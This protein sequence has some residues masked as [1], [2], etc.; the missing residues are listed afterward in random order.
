MKNYSEVTWSELNANGHISPVCGINAVSTPQVVEYLGVSAKELAAI[1]IKMAKQ[2][3]A[4]GMFTASMK[5]LIDQIPGAE[6]LSGFEYDLPLEDGGAVRVSP[7]PLVY[8]TAGAVALLADEIQN[9]NA[10]D[11]YKPAELK[12]TTSV[13]GTFL[14]AP[15]VFNNPMF[16]QVRVVEIDDEP[17][18][19]GKDVAAALGYSDADQALRKHVDDEDKL[20]RQFNGSGQ[21]R[22]ATVINESGLYSLV[23]SS[24]LPGAKKFRRWITSEVLPSIRKHG[25]YI[26]GQEQMSDEE[27]MAKALIMA[28]SKIAERDRQI[29]DLKAK[30]E[31]DA[32]KVAF[33]EAVHEAKSDI[34][35]EK[36]A[37]LLYDKNGI[38]VGRNNMFL[39]LRNMGYLQ[40]NNLPYQKYLRA[41]YFRTRELLK[42][43]YPFIQTLITG[44]GQTWLFDRVMNAMCVSR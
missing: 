39:L 44:K 34:T 28:Q 36:F 9:H 8:C 23:L 33:A 41:G 5:N 35:V 3:K 22:C 10:K 18:L 43:G 13:S 29:S 38:R 14:C 15:T 12:T 11:A 42:N 40:E 7:G 16:G 19:V 32:P 6:K 26:A 21:N 37:K 20:T 24:K 25:G 1:R 17:W 31:L 27:L 4:L 2:L 30:V